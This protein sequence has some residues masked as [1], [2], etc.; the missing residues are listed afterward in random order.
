MRTSHPAFGPP[1]RPRILIADGDPL[2][3]RVLRQTVQ[4]DR[5]IVVAEA[6]TAREAIEL[7][8]FYRP[9]LVLLDLTLPDGDGLDVIKR[10]EASVAGA[11]IV[12]LTS[13]RHGDDSDAM[14]ALRA[15]AVGFLDKSMSPQD[16]PRTLRGVLAG[17]AAISRCLG[18]ELIMRLQVMPEARIGM[19]PVRS[20]LTSREWEVFDL[21]CSSTSTNDIAAAL[22][23]SVETVRSHVKNILRKLGV[24][25]RAEAVAMSPGL[26][27]ATS[28]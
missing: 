7:A 10:V 26:R 13:G 23:L 6:G 11:A 17:E 20:S 22:Y 28:G 12:V 19:R 27:A 15:G 1:E 5:F 9:D 24:P 18:R 14:R 3:R 21:L 2:V 4:D 25:T 8:R 16:L